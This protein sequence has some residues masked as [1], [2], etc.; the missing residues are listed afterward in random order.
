MLH[1]KE[2]YLQQ[3]AVYKDS[4]LLVQVHSSFRP[5]DRKLP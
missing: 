4:T 1:N 3:Y 2:L 5:L